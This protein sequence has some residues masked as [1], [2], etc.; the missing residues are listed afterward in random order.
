MGKKRIANYYKNH[1]YMMSR[2][3]REAMSHNEFPISYWIERFSMPASQAEKLLIYMGIH[4]TGMHGDET[5]FY[6]LPDKYDTA[7]LMGIYHAFHTIAATNLNCINIMSNHFQLRISDRYTNIPL[8]SKPR[9][10]LRRTLTG[11][12]K[13]RKRKYRVL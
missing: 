5:K 13:Y 4:H 3:G 12:R 2:R 8:L 9:K 7:E 11:K 6:R 1:G 10:R